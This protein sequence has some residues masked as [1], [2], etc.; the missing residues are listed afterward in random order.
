MLPSGGTLLDGLVHPVGVLVGGG[1]HEVVAVTDDIT[2]RVHEV[3]EQAPEGGH[4]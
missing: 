2:D 3:V 4:H 1:Q